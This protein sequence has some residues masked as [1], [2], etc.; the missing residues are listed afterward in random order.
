[1]EIFKSGDHQ[2]NVFDVIAKEKGSSLTI[3][4]DVSY[5]EE[6]SREL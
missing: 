2:F 4:L 5:T 3:T 6:L 1:M